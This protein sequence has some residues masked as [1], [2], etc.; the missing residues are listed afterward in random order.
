[1]TRYVLALAIAALVGAAPAM[2]DAGSPGSTFPEQPGTHVS[3]G[4][5]AIISNP[6]TGVGGQTSE[7]MS[8]TANAITGGVLTDACFGG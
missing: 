3:S 5:V 1:M 4:C 2:A 7:S 6:G 8:A